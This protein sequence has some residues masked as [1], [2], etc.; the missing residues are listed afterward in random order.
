MVRLDRYLHERGLVQ[1]R[2]KARELIKAGEVQVGGEVVTKPSF[3]VKD[4]EV[5][6]TGKRYISRAGRKL[7]GFLNGSNFSVDQKTCLDVGASTGGFVQILLERGAKRVVAVD[8]GKDQLDP[9]LKNHPRVES[10]EGCDIRDFHSAER[11]DLVTCDLSFIALNHVLDALLHFA[12]SDIIV[13]YKPQFEVGKE[14]K[15]DRRGVVVDEKAIK[16][17]IE[18]FESTVCRQCSIKEK[19]RSSVA[20]KE[21]N[22][23]WFYH[24]SKH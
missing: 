12:K 19:S 11:F 5:K 17:A 2:N 8:V 9:E 16:S 20:G 23:E 4:E 7:E 1:S 15:R 10:V 18:N 13:L 24:L 6:I 21:G 22:I 3:G 14:A